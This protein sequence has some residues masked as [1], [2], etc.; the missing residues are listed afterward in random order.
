MATSPVNQAS[1]DTG[2]NSPPV[3]GSNVFSI[4]RSGDVDADIAKQ[5]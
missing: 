4:G 2:S 3:D 1:E 5:E